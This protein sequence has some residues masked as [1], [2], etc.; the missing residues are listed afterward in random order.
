MDLTRREFILLSGATGAGVALSA[1]G[2]DL[3]SV[4]AYAGQLKID[5][6]KTATMTTSI[7]P[8]CAVG[9]GLLVASDQKSGQILNIEGDPDHPINEGT[10][11]SKGAAVFQTTASNSNRLTKV[12]YRAP[13]SDKWEERSWDWAITEIAKKAKA[14]RD[15]TFEEK[16]SK[17][18]VVNR[19]EAIANIG[20][21][22]INNDEC[23]GLN[24]LVRG[25]GVV[26]VE[27]QA[28]I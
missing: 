25:L 8:Y 26:Y 20:S 12:L 23:W 4:R 1:L 18:Q 11:C 21:S 15:A 14:T 6:M 24:C 13:Y 17:G 22:N 27:H 7:C 16:N 10:L 19:T 3:G 28:R 2:L 9:C 5:K